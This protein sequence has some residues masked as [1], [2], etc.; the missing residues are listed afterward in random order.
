MPFGELRDCQIL[1]MHS[2]RSI[3][4]HKQST[5]VYGTQR[6]A[7]SNRTETI[8]SNHLQQYRC[9]VISGL[10]LGSDKQHR[11]N[12]L[13]TNTAH[14]ATGCPSTSQTIIKQF[15]HFSLYIVLQKHLL[16]LISHSL[17]PLHSLPVGSPPIL[18]PIDSDFT[19][20]PSKQPT[21]ITMPLSP[22]PAYKPVKEPSKSHTIPRPQGLH[23]RST[24][25]P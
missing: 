16:E 21:V 25:L 3:K 17:L 11:S 14:D 6:E 18:S 4:Q 24:F 10:F 8:L 2:L 5:S 9:F 19:Q 22:P 7:T 13:P 20:R 15:T 23:P 1:E 12:T